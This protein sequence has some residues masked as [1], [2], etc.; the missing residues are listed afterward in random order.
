MLYYI[1][2]TDQDLV[3]VVFVRL[4]RKIFRNSLD[5]SYSACIRFRFSGSTSEIDVHSR[6]NEFELLDSVSKP[7]RWGSFVK[8]WTK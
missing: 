1:E 8:E 6:K 2:V 4:F 5:L 3:C 7:M